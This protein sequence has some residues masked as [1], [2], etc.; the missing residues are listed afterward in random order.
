MGKYITFI[1]KEQ[2]FAL[3]IEGLEKIVLYEK[4]VVVPETSNY[5]LGYNSYDGQPMPLID[6]N[7]KFFDIKTE[8]K[9]ETKVI[10]VHWQEHRLGLLV[11]EVSR[12]QDYEQSESDPSSNETL[13]SYIVDTIHD[14]ENIILQVDIDKMFVGDNAKELH[15]LLK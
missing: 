5:I 2:L 10:V 3:P 6:L 11:D 7:R 8:I 4:P 14:G 12:V 15:R 1:C 9:E 13:E